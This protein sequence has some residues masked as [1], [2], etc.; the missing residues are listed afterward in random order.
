MWEREENTRGRKEEGDPVT[1]EGKGESE[2]SREEKRLDGGYC[3]GKKKGG[4]EKRG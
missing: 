4:R 3:E 2:E 1:K